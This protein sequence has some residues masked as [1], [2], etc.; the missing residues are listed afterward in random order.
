MTRYSLIFLVCVSIARAADSP[1]VL[2]IAI[3]DM[4][5]GISLFGEERPFKTPHIRGLA[6]RGVFFSRTIPEFMAMIRIGG[7]PQEGF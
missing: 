2:F 1:N 7:L 3:D 6:G 5:D 4:N